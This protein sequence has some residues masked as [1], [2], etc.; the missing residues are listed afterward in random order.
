MKANAASSKRTPVR[1][2]A[3][4]L[5]LGLLF[6]G[7]CSSNETIAPTVR[8]ESM[9]L[10]PAAGD[11]GSVTLGGRGRGRLVR[12]VEEELILPALGGKV[13]AGRYELCVP[14]LA[15]DTPAVYTIEYAEP[16][17]VQVELG[18][19]GAVF[20]PN[21]KVKLDIDLTGTTADPDDVITLYWYDESTGQWVDVGGLWNPNTMTLKAELE[22]FSVYRPGRAGW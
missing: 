19:H 13:H 8:D 1:L 7:A 11:S 9:W 18:P 16:G 10:V 4:L 21:R 22:H 17:I 20:N 3:S 12:V 2:S 5:A 15:L 14:P 6:L